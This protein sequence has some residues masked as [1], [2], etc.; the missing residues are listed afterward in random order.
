MTRPWSVGSVGGECH[1]NCSRIEK[2]EAKRPFCH[3]YS[4]CDKKRKWVHLHPFKGPEWEEVFFVVLLLFF[5]SC[6]YL[7]FCVQ[8]PETQT[9]CLREEEKRLCRGDHSLHHR[10]SVQV[11]GPVDQVEGSEQDGENYPRHLV[12][13]ADAVVGLLGVHH[14]GLSGPEL[15]RGGVG[16]G[17]DGHVLGEVGRV[18]DTC[19]ADV[20][21]LFGQHHGVAFLQQNRKDRAVSQSASVR[22]VSAFIHASDG[23]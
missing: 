12:D 3:S 10:L 6:R 1:A 22:E 7:L 18:V 13:L 15:H 21:G 16:D 14:L 8:R 11:R 4:G 2:K 20:V 5:F 17:G 19:R 23:R 9:L